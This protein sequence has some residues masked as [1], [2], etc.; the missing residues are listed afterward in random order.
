MPLNFT[1]GIPSPS[2]KELASREVLFHL[3]S[4]YTSSNNKGIRKSLP[5]LSISNIY[6]QPI[7]QG[8]ISHI[9]QTVALYSLTIR[10]EKYNIIGD[11]DIL[12][13]FFLGI[14][15]IL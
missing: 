12:E 2:R 6:H 7:S 1:G 5:D 11:T 9:S 13:S 14:L 10:I 3:L 8:H 4:T 15:H